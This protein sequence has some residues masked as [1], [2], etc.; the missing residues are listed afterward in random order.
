MTVLSKGEWE[1]MGE[2]VCIDMRA[3]GLAIHTCKRILVPVVA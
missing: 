2:Y 1:R 3:L